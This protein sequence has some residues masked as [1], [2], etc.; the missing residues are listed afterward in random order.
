[1]NI[2]T[3]AIL[4]WSVAFVTSAGAAVHGENKHVAAVISASSEVE[5]R[6]SSRSADVSSDQASYAKEEHIMNRQEIDDAHSLSQVEVQMFRGQRQASQSNLT[7]HEQLLEHNSGSAYLLSHTPRSLRPAL[8]SLISLKVRTR[9]S[10]GMVITLVVLVI[11]PVL[12][13]AVGAI[14][15]SRKAGGRGPQAQDLSASDPFMAQAIA[16]DTPMRSPPPETHNLPRAPEPQPPM[17]SHLPPSMGSLVSNSSS[18]LPASDVDSLTAAIEAAGIS[19]SQVLCPHMR[20]V[21]GVHSATTFTVSGLI[22]SQP[23]EDIVEVYKVDDESQHVLNMT[24]SEAP[25]ASTQEKTVALETLGLGARASMADIDAAYENLTW[26][27]RRKG[28]EDAQMTAAYHWL[29][30]ASF[31]GA[32]V[33]IDSVLHIPCAYIDTSSALAHGAGSPESPNQCF[34]R[35]THYGARAAELGAVFGIVEGGYDNEQ[36]RSTQEAAMCRYSMFRPKPD[37]S[38]GACLMT[39]QGNSSATVFNVTD[40]NLQLVAQC[41]S[42][43]A[44]TRTIHIQPGVDAT[45]VLSMLVSAVKLTHC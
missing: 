5:T 38:K 8:S 19:Q 37:G 43:N 36:G 26:R 13:I 31:K 22:T 12:A 6:P 24:F 32:G 40:E 23:Q 44:T 33:A 11:A 10:S 39:I 41:Q 42:V 4:T 20:V 7:E 28:I 14:Y 29:K 25:K 17:Q 1:M 16:K 34:V 18:K 30:R 27:N 2:H 35:H 45:M 15:I 21:G 9:E 3:F